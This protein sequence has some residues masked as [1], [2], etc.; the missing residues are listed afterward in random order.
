MEHRLFDFITG[1]I[2]FFAISLLILFT[3]FL[4]S[5]KSRREAAKRDIRNNTRLDRLSDEIGEIKKL[6]KTDVKDILDGMK[7]VL[8][9]NKLLVK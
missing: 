3:N 8:G 7:S 6:F 2:L 1:S 4:I 9:Q 5:V